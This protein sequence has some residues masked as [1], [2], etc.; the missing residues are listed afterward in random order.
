MSTI[1]DE[2]GDLEQR[3]LGKRLREI[4][5]YLGLSQQYVTATTG[6]ARTAISEIERGNRKV[7]SLELRRF[8]RAY[9]TSV[10]RLLG[11]VEE[12]ETAFAALERALVDLSPTDQNEVL[13]FAEFLSHRKTTDLGSAR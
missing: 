10:G 12:S 11:E 13:K 7:D 8:A 3:A 5:E 2:T 4:R 9:Q 1:S 6:I